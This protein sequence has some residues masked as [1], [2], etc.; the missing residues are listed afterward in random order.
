MKT[1][2]ATGMLLLAMSSAPYADTTYYFECEV[3]NK[4]SPLRVNERNKTLTWQGKKY[5]IAKIE[6]SESDWK[7][8]GFTFCTKTQHGSVEGKGCAKYGWSATGNGTSFTLCGTT[9]GYGYIEGK[10]GTQIDCEIPLNI[11]CKD[12]SV[13]R[14]MHR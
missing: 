9:Q 8:T 4:T 11:Y 13:G 10:D 3:G 6:C 12:N 14:C 2:I 1:I 7:T 5:R